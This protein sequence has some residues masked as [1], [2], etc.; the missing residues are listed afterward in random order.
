MNSKMIRSKGENLLKL[1]ISFHANIYDC[2]KNIFKVI[3][4]RKPYQENKVSINNKRT[5]KI[6]LKQYD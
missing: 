4:I 3:E 1:L 5:E 6:C 2:I